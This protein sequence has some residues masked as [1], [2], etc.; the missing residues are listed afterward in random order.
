[1]QGEENEYELE[2]REIFRVVGMVESVHQCASWLINSS[3]I[4]SC[5]S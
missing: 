2:S 1:M 4:N 3:K 5:A